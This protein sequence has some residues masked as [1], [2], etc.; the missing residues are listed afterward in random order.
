MVTRRGARPGRLNPKDLVEFALANPEVP[1]EGSSESSLH[2]AVYA[3]SPSLSMIHAYPPS[4]IAVTLMEDAKEFV[5]QT[6]QGSYY[7][8]V[9]PVIDAPAGDSVGGTERILQTYPWTGLFNEPLSLKK[10]VRWL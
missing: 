9:V 7:M 10:H 3:I 1:M 4:A 5:P 8:P 6:V 2:H